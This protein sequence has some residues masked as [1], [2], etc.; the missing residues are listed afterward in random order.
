[1]R[2]FFFDA[3]VV[4][5]IEQAEGDDGAGYE[6]RHPAAFA[7]FFNQGYEQYAGGDN[8]TGQG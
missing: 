3:R 1:M 4:P 8:Q 7:E 2:I 6:H 5:V